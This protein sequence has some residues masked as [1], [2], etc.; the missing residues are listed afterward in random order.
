MILQEKSTSRLYRQ[1]RNP[2]AIISAFRHEYSHKENHSRNKQLAIDIMNYID[3]G[4]LSLIGHWMESP[5]TSIDWR[6][7]PFKNLVDVKED[8]YMV[9]ISDN[10][11]F[12]EFKDIIAMLTAKYEQDASIISDG[13]DIYFLDKNGGMDH[14]AKN[15][16]FSQDAQ[17]YSTIQGKS[18]AFTFTEKKENKMGLRKTIREEVNRILSEENEHALAKLEKTADHLPDNNQW[19]NRFEIRSSS[20]NRVYTV[21]QN[22]KTNKWAC[23]CPGWIRFK[24]CKH[25]TSMGFLPTDIHG[26]HSIKEGSIISNTII[27]D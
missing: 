18:Q 11:S 2:F 27:K 10:I 8:S 12:D 3:V 21:A 6:E 14:F 13:E 25:L 23:S 5:D 20:S 9:P 15:I 17:A 26:N 4:G 16:H 7:V 19:T 22:K 1:M 24:K